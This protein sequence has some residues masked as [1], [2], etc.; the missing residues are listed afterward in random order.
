MA[1]AKIF[2]I[3]FLALAAIIPLFSF[4]QP[5]PLQPTEKPTLVLFHGEE[6]PHCQA[7]RKFLK[8]LKEEYPDLEII[9]YEVWH[10]EENQKLFLETARR[11]GIKRLAVPLTIVGGQFLIG[12]DKPENSGKAIRE[13]VEAEYYGKKIEAKKTIK[14]PLFGKVDLQETSLLFLSAVIGLLDGFNPC[15]MWALLVL[16]T[17]LISSGSRK[18]VWLVGG[19]FIL[20][21][22]FSYFLFMT[23]WLNAFIFISY[24]SIVRLAVGIFAV[25]AG[26][27]AIKGFFS[28]QPDVCEI[29]DDKYQA[30]ISERIKKAVYAHSL[31]AIILGVVFVAFSVNLV[32]L[33][34]SLGFPVI[35]T[36]ALAMHHLPFWQYYFYILIYVFFYMLDDIVVLV[37]AGLSMRFLHLNSKYSHYSRL[38]AGILML[39][40]GIIFIF[41]PELL[42]FN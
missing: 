27:A 33:M 34:C 25:G 22:A 23:A 13:M 14:L 29:S 40:L 10:N 12:F 39:A 6:C 8:S 38:L 31:A 1:R 41:K 28:R 9:E 16:L 4:A 26:A 2:F 5:T 24:L 42:M 35:F 18:K 11:L 19:V 36:N 30:K 37:A 17:L 21:S 7:E 3:S 20:T 32:E 15:S